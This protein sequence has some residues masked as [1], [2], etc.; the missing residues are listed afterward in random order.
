MCCCKEVA[1]PCQMAG[2]WIFG[3]VQLKIS[4]VRIEDLGRLFFSK[5]TGRRAAANDGLNVR[6][7]KLK[8]GQCTT[9][10]AEIE[11]LRQEDLADRTQVKPKS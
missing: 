6:S 2:R 3:T 11:S 5:L 7:P 4:L 1:R 8:M 10:K 9:L